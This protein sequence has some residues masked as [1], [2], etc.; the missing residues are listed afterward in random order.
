V[1]ETLRLPVLSLTDQVVLPGMVVPVELDEAAQA[2]I[3]AARAGAEGQ[4]LLAPRLD[5]RYPSF[6]AV[7]TI[8]QLGRLPGGKPAAVQNVQYP[9][10]GHLFRIP[11]RRPSD[12]HPRRRLVCVVA[13]GFGGWPT[14]RCLARWSSRRNPVRAGQG[15]RV[16]G[17]VPKFSHDNAAPAMRIPWRGST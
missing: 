3:D 5:D 1:T 8:E 10:F 7:A 4:L 17:V 6:G 2:A 15:D 16:A 11:D 12:D 14:H 13:T 9:G